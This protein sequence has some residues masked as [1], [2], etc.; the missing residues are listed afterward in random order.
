MTFRFPSIPFPS[1]H[2][3]HPLDHIIHRHLNPI[4]DPPLPPHLPRRLGVIHEQKAPLLPVDQRL[5]KVPVLNS[6][7]HRRDVDTSS[8]SAPLP[9][10]AAGRRA[11]Q[12]ERTVVPD[13]ELGNRPVA[14]ESGRGVLEVGE[15]GLGEG[16]DVLGGVG[17]LLLLLLLGRVCGF[18]GVASPEGE[19]EEGGR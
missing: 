8:S 6:V 13:A 3:L 11:P 9:R 18:R 4:R 7:V 16:V 2:L 19:E 17:L 15:D 12:P 5:Q 14:E 10:R 1:L